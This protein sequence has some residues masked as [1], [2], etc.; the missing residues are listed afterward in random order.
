MDNNK[1]KRQIAKLKE[2]LRAS[3]QRYRDLYENARV[4]LYRTRISDGKVLEFN[5]TLVRLFGYDNKEEFLR[6][7]GYAARDYDKERRKKL[8]MLLDKYGEVNGYEVKT[9]RKDGSE[10]WVRVFARAYPRE[11]YIEGAIVDITPEKLLSPAEQRVFRLIMEG[12]SNSEIAKALH[13]SVRTIEDHRAHIMRK[14]GVK[15]I[16]ELIKRGYGIF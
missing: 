2:K 11:G 14:L 12:M 16:V 8:L 10:M 4:A 5:N 13:R 3:E 15:N 7:R 1:A 6:A 9:Y